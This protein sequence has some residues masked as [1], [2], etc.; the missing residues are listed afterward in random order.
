MYHQMSR[1]VSRFR[2]LE[3]KEFTPT[4]EEERQWKILKDKLALP[5]FE[6]QMETFNRKCIAVTS[7]YVQAGSSFI[8]GNIAYAWAEKGIPVTLCELPNAISYYYFALDYERRTNQ[9]AY[10]AS[11]SMLLMQNNHLRIQIEPPLNH[12][13]KSTNIDMANWLL[14]MSKVSPIVLIDVSSRWTHEAKQIFEMADEIWV[15]FDGDLARLTR[16]FLTETAPSWWTSEKNKLK[17]I[18]NK[19]NSRLSRSSVL[20]KVEGTLSLWNVEPGPTKV[21]YMLP[22]IDGEKTATAHSKG[23]L[24]LEFFPEEVSEFQSLIHAYKGRML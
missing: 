17:F 20:K 18:A 6:E 12:Q 3:Q 15:V 2:D 5:L 19:W 8:A 14:R 24:L 13:Q 22:L 9:Q 1:F 16:L 23:N 11:T 10:N 7:L 21:E 4:G